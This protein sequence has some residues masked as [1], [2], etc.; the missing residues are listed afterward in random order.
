NIGEET[1]TVADMIEPYLMQIGF[2]KRTARGRM[3]TRAAYSH[4]G[5]EPNNQKNY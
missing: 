5:I 3:V 1:D 4:L 2:I